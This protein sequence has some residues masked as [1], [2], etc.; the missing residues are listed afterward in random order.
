M[1]GLEFKWNFKDLLLI[2]KLF[3]SDKYELEL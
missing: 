1:I 2:R 3:I